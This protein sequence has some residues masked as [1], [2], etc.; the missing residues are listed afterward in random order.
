MKK[1][2]IL[3]VCLI[4]AAT[5]RSQ[6]WLTAG[7]SGINPATEFLGTTDNVPLLF[8]VNNVQSG[9]IA[10]NG[11]VSLGF[12]ANRVN[13]NATN[14]AIG[15][16]AFYN[17]TG[18]G[19]DW[20]TAVGYRAGY[21][22]V[23]GWNSTF[24]G[25]LAGYSNTT[26]RNSTATGT[27]TLQA[28][29]T[30]YNN[31]A[32]GAFAL[33][34][35]ST[36]ENNTAVGFQS[37]RGNSGSVND[38][39]SEIDNNCVFVGTWASRDNSVARTTALTNAI[40]IGYDAKVGASNSMVLGGTGANAVNV[41]IG[42]ITPSNKLEI[43]H[44]TSG[45]SGLRFTNLT[46]SSTAGSPSSKLLS[47]N[48]NG[49]VILVG[50]ADGTET[51]VTAGTGISV[52][53][54]G[55]SGSA[56]VI[57]STATSYWTASGIGTNNVVNSNSGAIV[58]GTGITTLPSGYKLYVSDGILAEK[59][60]VALKSG[61]NWADYVFAKDYKLRPLSELESFIATNK[62]LP[63]IPSAET[64]VK[65]GGIDVNQMFAKQ[66]EKIEELTLYI[67]EINKKLEK[68]ERENAGMRSSVTIVNN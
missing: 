55:S 33:S 24:I 4:F 19:V 17:I 37:G 41:G 49:D 67:I 8:R 22:N 53:G 25:Y 64:L 1:L 45:N 60:K 48:S 57:S 56:Y 18:S 58:I 34:N 21:S 47:V 40:A 14:T 59:V 15:H 50:A 2:S 52:T 65:E 62:H 10:S 32:F 43:T 61:S 27:Y 44:G 68:L 63:G 16:Q 54:N 5:V 42:T 66:M 31:T 20:S 23:S 29:T 26:G 35:L 30:G 6:N 46:S 36:G 3:T 51:V 7:N 38:Y 11:F 13:S 39:F 28:L 9:N 12:E